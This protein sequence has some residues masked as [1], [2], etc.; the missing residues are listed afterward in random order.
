MSSSFFVYCT[1]YFQNYITIMFIVPSTLKDQDGFSL[2]HLCGRFDKLNLQT[3]YFAIAQFQLE[4]VKC[5][6]SILKVETYPVYFKFY[7]HMVPNG[8]FL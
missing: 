2:L 6:I 1:C 3:L 4:E 5:Q 8:D 7:M